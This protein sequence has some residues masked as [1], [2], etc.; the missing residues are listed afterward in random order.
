MTS[1]SAF[2]MSP[3]VDLSLTPLGL[4]E[5]QFLME[6][7]TGPA[8]PLAVACL[9][10]TGALEG[11]VRDATV[12]ALVA[13][14]LLDITDG[15]ELMAAHGGLALAALVD[16]CRVI[17]GISLLEGPQVVANGLFLGA[18]LGTASLEG[19]PLASLQ[20]S[21]IDGALPIVDLVWD[22]IDEHLGDQPGD[23]VVSLDI[24]RVGA[25]HRLGLALRIAEAST[26]IDEKTAEHLDEPRYELVEVRLPGVVTGA[27]ASESD[28]RH[29]TS[30]EPG[31]DADGAAPRV[32]EAHDL[33]ARLRE[34]LALD[35][36][37]GSN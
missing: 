20:L 10:V 34:L 2:A 18:P 37:V 13:R 36:P 11:E 30:G 35:A 22:V 17:A 31:Q 14:G 19:G 15:D 6:L 23:A 29:T 7:A 4:R 16:G 27:G 28:T 24:H 1:T 21:V 9:G 26:D 33:D 12:S 5:A 3:P 32:L 25:E 8:V